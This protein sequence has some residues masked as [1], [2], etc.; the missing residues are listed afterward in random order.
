MIFS[1]P[2]VDKYGVLAI[3]STPQNRLGEYFCDNSNN[4]LWVYLRANEALDKGAAVASRAP[5]EIASGLQA[6]AAGSRELVFSGVNLDTIFP[7][8]PNQP[9]FSEY[10][11]VQEEGGSQIGTVWEHSQTE[12]SVQWTSE[13]DFQLASALAASADLIFKTPWLVDEAGTGGA[14]IGFAQ[15]AIAIGQY[16]WALVEGFGWGLAGAAIAADT[17][18]RVSNA[19]GALDDAA[20]GASD[21]CAYSEAAAASGE[22]VPIVASAP[23]KIGILP[24]NGAKT[25][26]SYEHPSVN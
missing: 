20:S 4:R 8:V 2:K 23:K 9:R 12:M 24:F 10:M 19:N 13:L 15:R 14:V 22:L 5:Q 18:L 25:Q 17:A 16:F 21:P 6:A 7:R 1:L 3:H 26:I 11:M